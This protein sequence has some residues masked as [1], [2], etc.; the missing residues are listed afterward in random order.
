[1]LVSGALG[2]QNPVDSVARTA[3]LSFPARH[4]R[5]TV[6]TELLASTATIGLFD[7]SL[8]QET[9]KFRDGSGA[10]LQR[11]S[12][13]AS[14]VGGYL[15]LAVGGAMA[16]TGWATHHDFTRNLGTDVIKAVVASGLVTTAIKGTVGRARPRAVI[17][18][19]DKFSVGRG[20]SNNDLA[21]FPSG[22]VSAAFAGAMVLASELSKDHPAHSKWI[23]VGIFG[24]ATAIGYYRMYENAHWASDVYAG[25]AIGTLSGMWIVRQRNAK[26]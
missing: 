14:S 15:P 25:A 2:A 3:P 26:K 1:M 21:S 7:K 6:A 23:R 22:H 10:G 8:A 4:P 18:D 9:Q 20:F 5:A 17:D 19:P 13:F 12:R 24:A 11:A 16:L